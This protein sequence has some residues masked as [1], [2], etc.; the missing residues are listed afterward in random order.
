MC[1]EVMIPYPFGIGS[2]CPL[3]EWYT[4][5]CNSSKPYL[6]AF[7]NLE[8]L[9]VSLEQQTV[10]LNSTIIS[11]CQ[12]S[13][14]YS[15]DIPSFNLSGSP[16]VFSKYYN[17]FVVKGCGNAV[18][19]E[20]GNVLAG[21]STNCPDDT[22]SERNRCVGIE[23]ED[24]IR[25]EQTGGSCVYQAVN[26]EFGVRLLSIM[27]CEHY[28][29][30]FGRN[31]TSLGV[32]LG[33][34]ISMG[35]LF[36]TAFS[37]ALFKI[38]KKTRAKRR[39][40]WFFKRNGGLLLKEQEATD[41]SLADKTILFTSKELEIATD[42]FN[43]KRI[44]GR[45]GQSSSSMKLLVL[46]QVN[47]RNVVQLL[48]CCLETDVPM[49]V[50]EFISNGTLYE[51]IQ[52]KFPIPLN[53]RLQI[54]TEVAGALSYL[55]SET[56]VSIYHRDI[57]TTNILLDD[58]FRAKVSDFGTSRFVSI[59]QTHLTTLVKG[60]FG[61]MDPEYFQFSQF[62]EKSDVYSFGVVLVELLTREK[63]L[64]LTKFGEHRNL[65]TYFMEAMEEGRVMSIL[66]PLIFEEGSK[67]QLM[68]IA[69]LAMRCLSFNGVI[70]KSRVNT[71]RLKYGSIEIS[72]RI[73]L[74]LRI[75]NM[76]LVIEGGN[77]GRGKDG[78]ERVSLASAT[79]TCAPR[80]INADILTGHEPYICRSK[81][82]CF[83]V[84]GFDFSL[85]LTLLAC[86]DDDFLFNVHSLP[87]PVSWL[88]S[89]IESVIAAMAGMRKAVE[90][91]SVLTDKYKE[92]EKEL[93]DSG[94]DDSEEAVEQPSRGKS[95]MRILADGSLF[96][97]QVQI[98][99]NTKHLQDNSQ[100]R[101]LLID[102]CLTVSGWVPDF[103]E[104]LTDRSRTQF[105]HATQ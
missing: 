15:Y 3:N 21:C 70:Q 35:L 51:L 82:R 6:S 41:T 26:Y 24:C 4:V 80:A 9:N 17:I 94:T 85:E 79:S 72:N 92:M 83:D 36:L 87:M 68:A 97:I 30:A 34:S 33:V 37:Y 78:R 16:F 58:N 55:H 40:E 13:I 59:D 60:T 91:L 29:D 104:K 20:D 56:S 105:W 48:G 44:L 12:N 45:G 89:H 99:G 43:E 57:K 50:S 19:S 10:T 73:K 54:A 5:D 67:D 7:N 22:V 27:T 18:I 62:S 77:H 98:Q 42:H 1:G 25:C 90:E 32:I 101:F 76:V 102:F 53:M 75:E 64:S 46:S 100:S 65:A 88:G 8:I 49:L 28:P 96:L 66:D 61:Y 2:N 63:P 47:H 69:N 81:Q 103:R 31:K 38:I 95:Y 71:F 14:R 11:N 93:A 86:D 74:R 52:D 23:R 84:L 39:K